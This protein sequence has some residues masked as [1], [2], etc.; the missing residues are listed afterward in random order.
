MS[1]DR[2]Q[3]LGI[4][5]RNAHGIVG[6][7]THPGKK[8]KSQTGKVGNQQVR[9]PECGQS[10]SAKYLNYNHLPRVHGIQVAHSDNLPVP[11]RHEP[12]P[13]P[14]FVRTEMIV[15]RDKRGELWVCEKLR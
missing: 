1:F 2:S 5:K 15:L 10:M 3:G 14:E 11:I 13:M 4:H 12:A 9:C 8:K 6:N 7:R